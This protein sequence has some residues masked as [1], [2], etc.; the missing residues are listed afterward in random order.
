VILV[1]EKNCGCGCL[2]DK[3]TQDKNGAVQIEQKKEK[4]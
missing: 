2:G 1:S 3:K 4:K